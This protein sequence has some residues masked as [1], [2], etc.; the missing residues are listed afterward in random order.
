MKLRMLCACQL[1]AFTSS[2][3]DAPLDRFKS[4]T[5]CW[6]LLVPADFRVF[7]C[8]LRHGGA[9][10]FNEASQF[11]PLHHPKLW[12]LSRLG[13]RHSQTGLHHSERQFQRANR[14][15][16]VCAFVGVVEPAPV[17]DDIHQ[18]HH[19]VGTECRL[20][21]ITSRRHSS[22][23]LYSPRRPSSTTRILSSAKWYSTSPADV[24][25]DLLGRYLDCFRF[26]SHLCFSTELR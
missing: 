1:V 6:D 7:A 15:A 12:C 8:L 5:I 9:P 14:C 18:Y 17:T 22:A 25:H 19:I 11:S 16:R 26:L 20:S 24:F 4:P 13:G 21:A 10:C 23:I 3:I 2:G